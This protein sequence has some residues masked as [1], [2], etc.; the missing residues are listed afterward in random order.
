MKSHNLFCLALLCC[1]SNSIWATPYTTYTITDLGKQDTNSIQTSD[2]NNFGQT[3]GWYTTATTI[4]NSMGM[5]VPTYHAFINNNGVVR[6]IG[7]L[8]GNYSAGK[9][10]NN[11]G[12]VTGNSTTTGNAAVHA[13]FYSNE[14]MSDLG[15]LGGSY[16]Y[17][18]GINDSSKI[19]GY[20]AIT[21]NASHHAFIY[22]N[23]VMT[24]IGTLGGNNSIGRS[25]NNN[26]HVAGFSATSANGP[27]HAFLYRDGVMVDLGTLGGSI[28]GSYDINNAG[29]VVGSSQLTGTPVSIS[30]YDIHAF[31]Y[32]EGVMVDLNN[33]IPQNSGWSLTEAFT[34]NDMGQITGYGILRSSAGLNW[35]NF[36]LN[37]IRETSIPEPDSYS[38]IGVG[39]S[40]LAQRCHKSRRHARITSKKNRNKRK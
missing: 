9:S 33:L 12:Q 5:T 35:H 23:G 37:P 18:E 38:L 17:G 32:T 26:G 22:T 16:S 8:G 14:I 40:I 13:F 28:S 11:S 21:G 31:L 24:D 10:I 20:S 27:N 34:I 29:Q 6:D 1:F 3:T 39:L 15:T 7:T 19:T 4:V 25:L 36:L 2:T 30:P